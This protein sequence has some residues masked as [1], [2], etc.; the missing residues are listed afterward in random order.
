LMRDEQNV[1]SRQTIVESLVREME[2]EIRGN[3]QLMESIREKAAAN[4]ISV[5]EQIHADA[6][7]IVNYQIEQG[8]IKF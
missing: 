4:G 5:E 1:V 6:A 8:E 3:A 7:W 2:D